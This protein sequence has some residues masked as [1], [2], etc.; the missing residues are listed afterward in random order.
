MDQAAAGYWQRE[1]QEGQSREPDDQAGTALRAARR[2]LA[3]LVRLQ[4]WNAAG[5][6]F[7]H[8]LDRDS[9]PATIA[10]L[11]PLLQHAAD[12]T[13]GTGLQLPLRYSLTR[14]LALA[15]PP[16]PPG[17]VSQLL[18]E[19]LDTAVAAGDMRTAAEACGDLADL[20]IR[21]GQADDA[22]S[23]ADRQA[24]LI[25]R[26][27][28]GWWSHAANEVRR[29]RIDLARGRDS[30]VF[31][32]AGHLLETVSSY[33]DHHGPQEI[34]QPWAVREGVLAA[35]IDAADNLKRLGESLVWNAAR[36]R[37]TERRGRPR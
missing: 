7:R 12:S 10:A 37:S 29:L 31:T 19:L 36:I 8:V 30:E 15:Q 33:P 24:D 27:R 17:Q 18:S 22:L 4:D 20:A 1:L 35:G 5:T 2:A 9:S 16:A 6:M 11:L 28:L 26:G 14:A 21:Q 32:A 13:A 3:Y 23:L 34:A 25:S